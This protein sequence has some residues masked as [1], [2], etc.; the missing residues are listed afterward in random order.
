[1]GER[2]I[3]WRGLNGKPEGKRPFGLCEGGKIIF[4]MDPKDI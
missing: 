3:S 2:R 4:K 1:M